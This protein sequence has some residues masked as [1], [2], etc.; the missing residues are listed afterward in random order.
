[1]TF[2]VYLKENIFDHIPPE[3]QNQIRETLKELID[4]FLG[5]NKAEIKGHK[6]RYKL[7]IG[8]YRAFYSVDFENKVVLVLE[9]LTA[10]QAH[11]KYR[12]FD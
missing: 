7:R 10:E 11:K 12:L 4:P 5:G 2:E 9:I 6:N 1:M 3:R 8:N